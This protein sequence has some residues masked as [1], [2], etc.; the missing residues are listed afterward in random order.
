M[1]MFLGSLA[2][3]MLLGCQARGAPPRPE[4][5]LADFEGKGYGNWLVTG[6][7]FGT[8]TAQGTL[9]GQMPVNGYRG[10]GLASSFVGGDAATGTLASPL[11]KITRRDIIF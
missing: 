5:V 8:G 11:F 10:H 1:R 6:T 2:F 9:P 7:A 4:V 3:L